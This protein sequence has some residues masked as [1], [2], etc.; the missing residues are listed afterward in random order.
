MTGLKLVVSEPPKTSAATWASA[1]QPAC[2]SR[3][4]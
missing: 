4:A 2:E 3:Q 1:V